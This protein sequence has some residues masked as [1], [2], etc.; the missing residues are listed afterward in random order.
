MSNMYFILNFTYM[1]SVRA[2]NKTLQ[3]S[4]DLLLTEIIAD[5]LF[6]EVSFI[7]VE[8]LV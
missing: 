1:K 8:L 2:L 7:T 6:S 4:S 5:H 3:K